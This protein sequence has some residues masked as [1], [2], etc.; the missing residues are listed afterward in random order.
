[1]ELESSPRD[2]TGLFAPLIEELL[3]LRER[4]RQNKQ[5]KEADAVRDSLER[6]DILVED[7]EEGPR[8]RFK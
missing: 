2:K 6:A 4:F 3:E 1:M 5:W 7:T 8:W